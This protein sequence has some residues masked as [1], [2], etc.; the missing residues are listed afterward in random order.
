MICNS[1]RS[2]EI[3]SG[4]SYSSRSF[5]ASGETLQQQLIYGASGVAA[6]CISSSLVMAILNRKKSKTT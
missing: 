4:R 3:Y 2:R 1:M 6:G 5:I